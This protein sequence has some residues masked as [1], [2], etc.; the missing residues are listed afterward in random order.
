MWRIIADFLTL[1]KRIKKNE[2]DQLVKLC[3]QRVDETLKVDIEYRFND[4]HFDEEWSNEYYEWENLKD[5]GNLP[6]YIRTQKIKVE[7]WESEK[8]KFALIDGIKNSSST[9]EECQNLV[10]DFYKTKHTKIIVSFQEN[11]EECFHSDDFSF[12]FV[13]V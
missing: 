8:W 9:W 2:T 5:S 6:V 11:A 10:L 7:N 4:P 12:S 13:E 3:S 1:I